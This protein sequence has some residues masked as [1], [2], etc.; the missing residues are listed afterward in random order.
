MASTEVDFGI[1]LQE[2]SNLRKEHQSLHFTVPVRQILPGHGHTEIPPA[3]LAL[4][5]VLKTLVVDMHFLFLMF[6]THKGDE[7]RFQDDQ[8]ESVSRNVETEDDSPDEEDEDDSQDGESG[9]GSKD[10]ESEDDFQDESGEGDADNLQHMS[11]ARWGEDYL[12]RSL[13]TSLDF[14]VMH[15]SW[16]RAAYTSYTSEAHMAGQISQLLSLM[17][18]ENFAQ[19]R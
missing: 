13:P 11:G 1:R 8:N 18:H 10:E 12:D 7:D 5:P 9:D 6:R 2:A 17:C 16:E 15:P 19:L 3:R 4:M 14:L